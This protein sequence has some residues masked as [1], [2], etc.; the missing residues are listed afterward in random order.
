MQQ[1]DSNGE[2]PQPRRLNRCQHCAMPANDH[3]KR[4]MQRYHPELPENGFVS[5]QPGQL[6]TGAWKY[7]SNW[8]H[9]WEADFEPE[10]AQFKQGTTFVRGNKMGK[11]RRAKMNKKTLLYYHC[12]SLQQL[13]VQS[14]AAKKRGSNIFF[15]P[16][17]NGNLNN[18]EMGLILQ[19]MEGHSNKV[20]ALERWISRLQTTIASLKKEL[21]SPSRPCEAQLVVSVEVGVGAGGGEVKIGGK[22]TV[23]ATTRV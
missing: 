22:K 5:L 19:D 8:E 18:E 17:K 2:A 6:P 23:P 13:G 16:E 21:V 14:E 9:I 20:K 12:K 10:D 4:H 11:K 7:C 15:P 1:Q 3:K